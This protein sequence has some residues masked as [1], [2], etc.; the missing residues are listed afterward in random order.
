MSFLRIHAG[1]SQTTSADAISR[2]EYAGATRPLRDDAGGGPPILPSATQQIPSPTPYLAK[3]VML[4]PGEVIGLFVFGKK[5]IVDAELLSWWAVVCFLALLVIRWKATSEG[6]KGPQKGAIF[7]SAVSFVLWLY[8]MGAHLP[9]AT[10]APRFDVVPTLAVALWTTLMPSI[11][12][13]D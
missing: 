11:Y 7:I 2:S 9:Y 10:L 12:K 13:G 4:I 5:Q 3:L 6:T 8:L 1:P